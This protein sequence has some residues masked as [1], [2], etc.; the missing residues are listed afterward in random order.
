MVFDRGTL[1]SGG[2]QWVQAGGSSVRSLDS[3]LAN[4]GASLHLC[5]ESSKMEWKRVADR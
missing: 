2:G 5:S 4:T 3:G 1:E